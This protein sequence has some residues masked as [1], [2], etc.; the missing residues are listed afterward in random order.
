[1]V[2]ANLAAWAFAEAEQ[3]VQ[4][5]LALELLADLGQQLA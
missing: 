4:E 5:S 2:T 3:T 1:V